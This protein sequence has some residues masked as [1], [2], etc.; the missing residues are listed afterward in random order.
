MNLFTGQRWTNR[1]TEKTYGYGER[2]GEG[3]VYGKSN[4]GTYITIFNIDDQ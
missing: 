2:G 3:E 4:M 1:H